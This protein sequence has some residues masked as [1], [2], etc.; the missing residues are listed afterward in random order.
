M[1][2]AQAEINQKIEEELAK[3]MRLIPEIVEKA[4]SGA[5][6]DILGIRKD[7][8]GYSVDTFGGKNPLNAYIQRKVEELM[9]ALIEPIV[10]KELT[11]LMKFKTLPR[12]VAEEIAKQAHYCFT[13]TVKS[14]VEKKMEAVGEKAASR[15]GE[16][17]ENAL[18]G[19]G[20]I[21]IDIDDPNSYEGPIGEVLL[22]E[23]A[24]KLAN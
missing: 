9:N 20:Q 7:R 8:Q 17:L 14:K 11:R 10:S 15:V 22:E 4:V 24:E 12:S 16:V 13:R 23:I 2:S 21:N 5:V 18:D 1:Q 3:Q 6:L 19:V